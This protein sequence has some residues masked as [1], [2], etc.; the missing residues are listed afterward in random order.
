[1]SLALSLRRKITKQKT[2]EDEN[3]K[4][5]KKLNNSRFIPYQGTKF[6]NYCKKC[7]Y[8]VTSLLNEN[9]KNPIVLITVMDILTA[10][11]NS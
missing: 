11:L 2:A 9:K 8:F 1:M 7:Q 4:N 10:G 5:S 3:C 6:Q